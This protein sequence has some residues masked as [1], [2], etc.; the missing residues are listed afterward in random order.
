VNEINALE[1]RHL[2]RFCDRYGIDYYEVDDSLT[3]WEN[4]EHLRSIAHMLTQT[5]DTFEIERMAELQKQYMA[6]HILEYYLSC[7]MAGETAKTDIGPPTEEFK[8]SLREYVNGRSNQ[9]V[10]KVSA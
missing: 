4:L 10:Q 1:K 9:A 7:Q 3:Y 5:L 2:K 6:E 8:F